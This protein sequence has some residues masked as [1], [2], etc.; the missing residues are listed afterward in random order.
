MADVLL[1]AGS[2]SVSSRSGAVLLALRDRIEAAGLT[3]HILRVRDLPAEALLHAQFDHPDIIEAIEE[4]KHAS[5][6]V[7]ATPVYKASFAG[8]LK[9]F[10]DLLPQNALVDKPVLP[11]ATGGSP[12]HLLVLE[13]SLKPVLATLG[14]CKFIPGLYIQDSQILETNPPLFEA[15][16]E[17]RLQGAANNFAAHFATS[18]P[19]RVSELAG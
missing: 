19:L 1:V 5:A 14:A 10:L 11:V 15:D 13:Y 12:A 8:I 9:T 2:P 4:V 17:F 7:V 3:T 16:I 18:L 6:L